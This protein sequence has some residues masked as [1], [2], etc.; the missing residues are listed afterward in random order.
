MANEVDNELV[1]TLSGA[2]TLAGTLTI[3]E[4]LKIQA[5]KN[6]TPTTSS[7]EVGPDTGYDAMAQVTVGAIRLENKT[8]TPSDAVQTISAGEN[9]DGLG[10]VTVE[11]SSNSDTLD[12][13][14]NDGTNTQTVNMTDDNAN[15]A[16][17]GVKGGINVVLP[18]TVTTIEESAFKGCDFLKSISAPG[19][20]EIKDMAF[21]SC[22]SLASM[23]FPSV[24][25]IGQN[26]FATI[27]NGASDRYIR[28]PVLSKI[29][30]GAFY[31]SY[32]ISDIYI[33]YNGVCVLDSTSAF[34][35]S[36][37]G[38]TVHVPSAQLAGYQADT[39]WADAVANRGLTLVGDYE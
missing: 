23:E 3:P 18:N 19:V 12:A 16:C 17:Y 39:T 5:N 31:G 30:D 34:N 13:L 14:M 32:K 25:T 27:S 28:F 22:Y 36:I 20:T 6:I 24:H 11:A 21:Q 15:H 2:S 10:V 9:Y 33:G 29:K 35:R 37:G 1:G 8:V 7:Q 26:A 4:R 38:F